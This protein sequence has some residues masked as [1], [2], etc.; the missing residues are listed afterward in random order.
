[1]S[2]Q[3]Q[4]VDYLKVDE[5]ISGQRFACVSF[6]E[7]KNADLLAK[8]ESFFM[9]KFMQSFLTDYEQ[10]LKYKMENGEEKMSEDVKDNLNISYDN[11]SD[12]YELFK[13][14]HLKKM[15]TDFENMDEAHMETTVRGFKVRG[16]YPTQAIAQQMAR[17][18]HSQEPFADV[19]LSQVGYWCPWNPQN[20][21]DIEPEYDE[22]QL[23]QLV[24]SKMDEQ[25]KRDLQFQERKQASMKQIQEEEKAKQVERNEDV[26]VMEVNDEELLEVL[27]DDLDLNETPE[28]K[29][30]AKTKKSPKKNK[31]VKKTN[32]RKGGRRK[33]N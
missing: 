24:K 23:N 30:T 32:N 33:K 11:L 19:F 1:M 22:E 5:P 21:G 16:C 12:K 20:V 3:S 14:L 10:A 13:S 6:V 28:K 31:K 29:E 18:Y 27:D 7:P 15:Q 8:R 26:K 25:A 2:T 17:D 4:K 9:T